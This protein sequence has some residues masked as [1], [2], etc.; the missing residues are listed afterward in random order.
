[1]AQLRAANNVATD[2]DA[3]RATVDVGMV[4]KQLESIAAQIAALQGKTDAASLQQI[5]GLKK[6]YETLKAQL[7]GAAAPTAPTEIKVDAKPPVKNEAV[8]QKK[9]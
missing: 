4:K 6:A 7:G 8:P 5:D 1:M 3:G 2:G 9:N